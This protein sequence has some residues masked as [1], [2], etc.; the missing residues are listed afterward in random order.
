MKW[1]LLVDKVKPGG[2]GTSNE[3]N[4]DRSSLFLNVIE[5]LLELLVL[6]ETSFADFM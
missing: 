3:G 1:G 2:S 6:T 5:N 4:I